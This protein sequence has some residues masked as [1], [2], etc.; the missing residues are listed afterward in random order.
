MKRKKARLQEWGQGRGL[1]MGK[2]EGGGA[3]IWGEKE[4]EGCRNGDRKG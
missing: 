2:D 4:V 1:Q 3:W